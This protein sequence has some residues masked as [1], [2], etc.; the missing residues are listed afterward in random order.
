MIRVRVIVVVAVA[1]LA[2]GAG[3]SIERTDP[4]ELKAKL[5]AI[6]AGDSAHEFNDLERNDRVIRARR[7]LDALFPA[8]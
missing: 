8:N 3:A 7:A 6:K 1:M 2:N 5:Q 4:A